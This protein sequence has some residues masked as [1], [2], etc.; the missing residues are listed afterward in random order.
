MKLFR[1]VPAD[2]WERDGRRWFLT[3]L[4]GADHPRG[5]M[6]R[7][8]MIFQGERFGV[9]VHQIFRPDADRDCHNHPWWFRTVVLRGGY[10]EQVRRWVSTPQESLSTAEHR[11]GSFHT[12]P[13]NRFHRIVSVRPNTWTLLLVGPKV[14]EWGF[15]VTRPDRPS[16]ARF[17]HWRAYGAVSADPLDA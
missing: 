7:R 12:M 4:I 10:T 17:V 1:E 6:L 8:Y 5:P 13:V 11:P 16:R 14:H 9:Y 3:K 2:R 15:W